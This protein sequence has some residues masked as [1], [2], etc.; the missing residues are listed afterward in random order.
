MPNAKKE[1]GDWIYSPNYFPKEIRKKYK[2]GEYSETYK[3]RHEKDKEK[4]KE[5]DK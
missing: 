2:L 4:K 5:D 1:E 3:K